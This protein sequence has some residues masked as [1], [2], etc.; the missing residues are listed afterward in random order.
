MTFQFKIQLKNISDPPVWRRLVVPGQFTFLRLH[1]TIQAA[2]GWENYHLFQFSPKG[3]ASFP[4]IA[5]PLE[6][7]DIHFRSEPKQDASKIKLS[8]IFTHPKQTF[9]Y[10]YD[11][12]D[13]WKHLIT[14]EKISDTKLL[15]AECLAGQGACP[16]EDC[17]GPWGY[18]NLIEV[19]SNPK[20]PEHRETKEWLG[21]GPKDKWNEEEFDLEATIKK[22]RKVWYKVYLQKEIMNRKYPYQNLSLEDMEGKSGR[23][24]PGSKM[25]ISYPIM[26][27]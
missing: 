17:G 2:F 8:E 18:A 26:A 14:L 13:D 25:N 5:L 1:M 11:F 6:D 27:V 21:L 3:Y 16:P 19:L 15:R 24:Y 9:T 10:I 12:G 20:H 23:I 22:V 7:D 4:I